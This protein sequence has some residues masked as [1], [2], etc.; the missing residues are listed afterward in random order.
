MSFDLVTG[1]SDCIEAS[2]R[3]YPEY[4]STIHWEKVAPRNREARKTP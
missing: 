2:G 1:K 3:E 4:W